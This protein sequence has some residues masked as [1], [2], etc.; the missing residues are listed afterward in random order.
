MEAEKRKRRAALVRSKIRIRKKIF[1]TVG[2]PR[3]TVFRSDKHIYAQLVNDDRSTTLA[4]ASTKEHE[5][6]AR[7][8]SG[9]SLKSIEAAHT[10]GLVLGERAKQAGITSV[11]FDRNGLPYHGRIKGLADGARG[12]GLQF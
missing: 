12:A 3:L 11:V 7:V 5:I 4:A 1:G 8:P 2:R 6:I 9:K 10:V